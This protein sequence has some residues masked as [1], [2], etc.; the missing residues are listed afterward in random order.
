MSRFFFSRRSK[1]PA[2]Q[3]ALATLTQSVRT[4]LGLGEED[5]LS[6]SEI[7]CSHP[8]CGDAETV[9]LIMRAGHK[10]EAV[11]ILKSIRLI[12]AVDLDAALGPVQ[13]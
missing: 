3:D 6:I 9:I 2:E 5:G 7:A 8:E 1:D 10:T 12:E 11:K 13:G 4:R